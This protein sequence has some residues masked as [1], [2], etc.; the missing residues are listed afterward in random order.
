[1]LIQILE[2]EKLIGHHFGWHG[3][4]ARSLDIYM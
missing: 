2:N 1:M 4:N 3:Q